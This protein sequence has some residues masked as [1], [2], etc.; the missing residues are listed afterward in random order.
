ML[1]ISPA[2]EAFD[3]ISTRSDREAV[4]EECY[5][6]R[7]KAAAVQH[8]LES[9]IRHGEGRWQGQ[10]LVLLAWQLRLVWR[11][12]GWMRP[13]GTRRFRSA[14]IELPKKNGKSSLIA[15][16]VLYMLLCDG[17]DGAQCYLGGL[18]RDQAANLF[19]MIVASVRQDSDL[20]DDLKIVDSRKTIHGPNGAFVRCLSADAA[21]ADGV[22]AHL[23]VYDEAHQYRNDNLYTVFQGSGTA[24]AQPLQITITTA[25][26][27]FTTQC[28]KLRELSERVLDGS[29]VVLQHE[30]VIYAADPGDDI[31]DPRVW[32][33]ANPSMGPLSEGYLIDPAD[34]GAELQQALALGQE[35]DFKRRR[36]GLWQRGAGKFIESDLWDKCALE[37][38]APGALPPLEWVRDKPCYIGVDLSSTLDISSVCLLFGSLDTTLVAFSYNWTPTRVALKRERLNRGKFGTWMSEGWLFGSPGDYIDHRLISKFIVEASKLYNVKLVCV[39]KWGDSVIK[40]D[41]LEA[42]VPMLNLQQGFLSMNAPTKKLQELVRAEGRFY[43]A[44]PSPTL[45]WAVGNCDL[46]VDSTGSHKVNRGRNARDKIDPVAALLDALGACLNHELSQRAQAMASAGVGFGW[47]GTGANLGRGY[48]DATDPYGTPT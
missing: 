2:L 43:H 26:D 4:K 18:D 5:F 45:A 32:L 34:F 16:I 41:L 13:D 30:G 3:P 9:Y 8:F 46:L 11:L 42:G 23:V 44:G 12:F 1:T 33:K 27:N 19:R 21:K 10:T 15:G 40:A 20:A 31:H 25:G 14:Y 29:S 24:R 38:G 28:W 35:A 47:C 36:L 17:E 39:D 48:P 7:E 6:D 22:S 37:V